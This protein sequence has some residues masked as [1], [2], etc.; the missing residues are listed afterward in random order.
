MQIT[1][2][3][4]E[5]AD[6]PALRDLYAMPNAQAGTLQLPFPTLG[7][8]QQRLEQSG[9]VA[10]IAEVEGQLVGQIAL[11]VEP[12]PRRKHVASIGMGVRDDWAGKGVGSALLGAVLEMA[13]NWLNLH[14]IELTVYTDNEAAQALYRKFGFAEEGRARDYAFRQG[15]YVDALYMARVAGGASR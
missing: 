7:V 10:L 5:P 14:R 3:H 15:R 4:A 8:W 12:N 9:V 2:R 6:A 1:I 11:H 13:D